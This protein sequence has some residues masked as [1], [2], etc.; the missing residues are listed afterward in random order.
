[1]CRRIVACRIA[2]GRRGKTTTRARGTRTGVREGVVAVGKHAARSFE[3]FRSF[4]C[5]LFLLFVGV[6]CLVF[7]WSRL[8]SHLSGAHQCSDVTSM[9][10][11]PTAEGVVSG[12]VGERRGG[13]PPIAGCSSCPFFCGNEALDIVALILMVVPKY[14]RAGGYAQST[15]T[16][17]AILGED[18]QGGYWVDGWCRSPR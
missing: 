11:L 15:P 6:L 14:S 18:L 17:P 9:S 10:V 1:M 5:L 13:Q 16:R 4:C 2:Q 8:S 12:G 3:G 7:P